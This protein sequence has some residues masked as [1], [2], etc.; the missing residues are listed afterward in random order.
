[1][2]KQK[3]VRISQSVIA[4]DAN[5]SRSTVSLV[6][7]NSNL[8]TKETRDRVMESAKKFGYKNQRGKAQEGGGAGIIG[9]VFPDISNIFYTSLFVGINEFFD[10]YGEYSIFFNSTFDSVSKQQR[11][12]EDLMKYNIA[13]LIIS[14]AAGTTEKDLDFIVKADI[15]MIFCPRYIE[16]MDVSFVGCDYQLGAYMAA[17]HLIENNHKR[18]ALLGGTRGISPFEERLKGYKM[19]LAANCLPYDEKLQI[20]GPVTQNW[21][22]EAVIQLLSQPDP[23]SAI[24]CY[25]DIIGRGVL[26]GLSYMKLSPGEDIAVVGFDNTDDAY[27]NDKM[28]TVNFDTPTSDTGNLIYQNCTSVSGNPYQWGYEAAKLMYR[29]IT[30]TVK[31]TV[32]IVFPQRL[33]IRTSSSKRFK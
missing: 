9:V 1:M 14:P 17:N 19:A 4:K 20:T 27:N 22:R 21:G 18:I 16:G 23:P 29:H 5:V 32:K 10:S 25:N 26:Q 24:L 15:P 3:K 33:I 30:G 2:A 12:L 13:G 11:F 7:R 8:V 31:E 28:S 6:L